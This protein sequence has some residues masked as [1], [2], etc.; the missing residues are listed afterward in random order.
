MYSMERKRGIQAGRGGMW[1]HR[2]PPDSESTELEGGGRG[3]GGG[4]PGAGAEV[5]G[6]PWGAA[7]AA[8]RVSGK[9]RQ[10]V[11]PSPGDPPPVQG[12]PSTLVSLP[13]SHHLS[14]LIC[15]CWSCLTSLRKQKPKLYLPTVTTNPTTPAHASGPVGKMQEVPSLLPPCDPPLPGQDWPAGIQRPPCGRGAAS[16]PHSAA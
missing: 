5:E 1:S 7:A 13:S 4:L 6:R 15:N 3:G 14:I 8:W 9:R 10:P 2:R 12:G 11:L 16:G